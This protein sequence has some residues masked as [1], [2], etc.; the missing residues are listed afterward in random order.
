MKNYELLAGK[1]LM[2]TGGTGSFGHTILK[3]CLETD[4]REVMIF[5][6]DEKRQG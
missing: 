2:I 5:S 1:S 3:R 6:C 4:I